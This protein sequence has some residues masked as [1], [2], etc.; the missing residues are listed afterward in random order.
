LV[1]VLNRIKTQ[2]DVTM[3][4]FIKSLGC[5]WVTAVSAGFLWAM[6]FSTPAYAGQI[7]GWVKN[8]ANQSTVP[9]GN[10]F[11][12]IA[13]GDKHSLAL[14]C[15]LTGD[16]NNDS[17]EPAP[18]VPSADIV[19]QPGGDNIVNLL[20]LAMMADHWLIDCRITPSDPACTTN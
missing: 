6:I 17:Y 16:L 15:I 18:G 2:K 12:V 1:R 14:R 9:D 20:D 5:S 8:D 11:I 4:S 13:A 10:D 7:F 3:Q 19:P